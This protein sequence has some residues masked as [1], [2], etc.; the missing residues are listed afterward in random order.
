M[1]AITLK[2]D[3]NSFIAGKLKLDNQQ[4]I[5]IPSEKDAEDPLKSKELIQISRQIVKFNQN[6]ATVNMYIS[7]KHLK[8]KLHTMAKEVFVRILAIAGLISLTIFISLRW[9]II[10]PLTVL[11]EGVNEI[12]LDNLTL[13]I[14]VAGDDEISRVAR[15]FAKMAAELNSSFRQQETLLADLIERDE[16]FR[17]IVSNVPGAIYRIRMDTDDHELLFISDN[18]KEISGF[19][20]GNFINS[21]R[22]NIRDIIIDSDRRMVMDAINEALKQKRSYDISYRIIHSSGGYRWLHETGQ[23]LADQQG[24]VQ[25][26]DGI[27]VDTTEMHSKDEQLRQSQKMETVGILAGGI[28]HDFNNILTCIIGT[29]ELV[30]MKMEEGNF[31]HDN[32]PLQLLDDIELEAERASEL[33]GQLLTLSMKQE[34]NLRPIDLNVSVKHIIKLA[35]STFDRSIDIKVDYA[36]DQAAVLGDPVQVEQ[37]ILNLCVNAVHAMTLMRAA[38]DVWGGDLHIAI[39][40]LRADRFLCATYP[41][42]KEQDYWVISI[43]DTGIGM[44]KEVMDRIFTPFF[45]TKELG[46]GSGLGLSMVYNIVKQHQGFL[47][48]YSEPGIGST[49]RIHIPM[50]HTEVAEEGAVV[51]RLL[52]KGSGT[53]LIVDDEEIIR[54]NAAQILVRCGFKILLAANGEIGIELFRK[55]HEEISLVLLDMVMPRMSGSEVYREIQS[56]APHTPVLLSSGFKQDTRIQELLSKESI[57]F[58]HKPYTLHDLANRVDKVITNSREM[59]ATQ[60]NLVIAETDQDH[61]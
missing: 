55:Y 3:S 13:Q 14:P 26:L 54:E 36:P 11:E 1:Q 46:R 31:L 23:P 8:T 61:A 47:I 42:A 19:P 5:S 41:E 18:I 10:R 2:D 9:L 21:A 25:W 27:L 17:S 53:V 15:S 45:S 48:V 29:T 20:P 24:T 40:P 57:Q 4:I 59:Y 7:D 39:T 51:E 44:T 22:L 50:H 12:T 16:R 60:C 37:V 58:I 52:P 49:F 38:E 34:T 35:Q 33:V 56:I 43:E 28:A 30:R 32:S 6:I